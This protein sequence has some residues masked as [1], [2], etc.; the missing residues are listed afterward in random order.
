[1]PALPA[2]C[3]CCVYSAGLLYWLVNGAHCQDA[4]EIEEWAGHALTC[5]EKR[6]KQWQLVD[7]TLAAVLGEYVYFV[8][9][10]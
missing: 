6:N 5:Y 1:M 2:L 4:A 8:L 9:R 3:L 10:T 7:D